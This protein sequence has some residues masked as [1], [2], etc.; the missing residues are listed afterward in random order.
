MIEQQRPRIGEIL[1][2]RESIDSQQLMQAIRDQAARPG[3]RL[4]S[5]LV[6][7]TLLDPDEGALALSEQ[8]GF[9][10]ALQRHLEGRQHDARSLVPAPIAQRWVVLP[11]GR[12]REGTLVICARDPTPILAAALKHALDTPVKLA[13]TPAFLLERL[14][15]A[16]Y[17]PTPVEV[18]EPAPAEPSLADIGAIPV[19]RHELRPARTVSRM[20]RGKPDSSLNKVPATLQALDA[21]L[22]EIDHA[23]SLAAVERLVIAFAAQR[24]QAA[25]LVKIADGIA[26][27]HRGHGDRLG[28]VD[29]FMLPLS[30][31]SL[32]QS[33]HDTARIV[34]ESPLNEVQE[35]LNSLLGDPSVPVAGPAISRNAVEAVLVVGDAYEG[36]VRDTVADLERLLDALGAAYD[37]FSRSA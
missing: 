27:G 36:T 13:V 4:V 7:R 28:A 34:V 29:A 19:D 9:P 32:I 11:I 25:L 1:L 23:F 8:T 12:A 35:R 10:A 18:V 2:L 33:A 17:G 15:T 22:Q 26:M 16:V 24:W 5:M 6:K 30:T 37:R 20:F 3:E 31:P 21:T 14:I